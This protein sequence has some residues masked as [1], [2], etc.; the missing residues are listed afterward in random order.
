MHCPFCPA[1]D[2]K[3]IDSRLVDTDNQVRRR[4]ECIECGERFTSYETAELS[5]PRVIKK[6]GTRVT[7]EEQK[8]RKGMLKALEKRPVSMEAVET[9]LKQIMR[10]LRETGEPEV[11]SSIL[12]DMVMEALLSL[13]KVAYIRFAS[14]Y[15][16]FEDLDAFREE[17]QRLLKRSM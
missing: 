10:K 16:R 8:L 3:V 5:M 15:Q 17:I 11:D 2:T 7:F 12:G 13:D 9:A 1:Q 4:R 14:V 6:D